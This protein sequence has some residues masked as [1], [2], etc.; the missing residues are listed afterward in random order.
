MLVDDGG[1]DLGRQLARGGGLA[2][3][4]AALTFT[5]DAQLVVGESVDD[6]EAALVTLAADEGEAELVTAIFTSSI[7]SKLK[8]RRLASPAAVSRAT[9]SSCGLAGMV[10]RT[11]SP[12][13]SITSRA[14]PASG[15]GKVAGAEQYRSP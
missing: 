12:A 6:R 1:E 14:P 5:V 9:R 15:R 8:P 7:S 13:T 2:A 3:V 4:G 10:R 11:S